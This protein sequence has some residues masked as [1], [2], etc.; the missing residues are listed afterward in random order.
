MGEN[1]TEMSLDEVLSSI[2]KMVVDEEPPVLDLTNMVSDDGKIVNLKKSAPEKNHDMSSF[3][4]LI[5]ENTEK[6]ISEPVKVQSVQKTEPSKTPEL[7]KNLLME[8][9]QSSLRP[10]LKEWLDENLKNIVTEIVKEEIK[11]TLYNNSK[12]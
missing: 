6:R 7:K 10:I 9:I 11:K 8:V 2:K 5:Q 12:D 3:L 4:Q 1:K